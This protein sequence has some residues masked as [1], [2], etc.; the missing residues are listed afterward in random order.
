MSDDWFEKNSYF[1]MSEGGDVYRQHGTH[2]HTSWKDD[3]L[4]NDT[5]A[6]LEC[7]KI[8]DQ[9]SIDG[10]TVFPHCSS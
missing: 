2:T 9:P 3:E 4:R 1:W 10:N 5:Q 7:K 8:I 6:N